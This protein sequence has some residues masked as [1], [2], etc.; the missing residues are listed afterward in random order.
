MLNKGDQLDNNQ[1]KR[2]MKSRHLLMLSLGGVIG[3]G[4]FLNV[5]YTINQA[6]PGGALIG[7]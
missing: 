6:G 5:G 1:L 4:L 2:S 7:Y 3:T